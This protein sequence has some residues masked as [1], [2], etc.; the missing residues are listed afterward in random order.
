[1]EW[2]CAYP[3][4]QIQAARRATDDLRQSSMAEARHTEDQLAG[5]ERALRHVLDSL[6]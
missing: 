5:R 3:A 2:R 6:K 1:V 4:G